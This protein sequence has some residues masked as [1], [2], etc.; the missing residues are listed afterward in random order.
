MMM[1]L[2]KE[3]AVIFKVTVTAVKQPVL[4]DTFTELGNSR[5]GTSSA[6]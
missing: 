1:S 3:T 4:I 6:S 2:V 5:V